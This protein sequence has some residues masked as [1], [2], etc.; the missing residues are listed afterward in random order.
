MLSPG[1][2]A[3]VLVVG[4]LTILRLWAA[5]HAGLA[6][7]GKRTIGFLVRNTSV[8]LCRSPPD[9][10][11]VDLALHPNLGDSALGVRTL[12]VLSALV[13]SIAVLRNWKATVTEL[14]DR[15]ARGASV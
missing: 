6:P 1:P 15:V 5:A 4:A 2:T 7:D 12:P 9:D 3:V 13:T 11:V 8:R 14:P 10:C